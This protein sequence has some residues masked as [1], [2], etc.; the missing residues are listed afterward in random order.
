MLGYIEE[1][2]NERE[3]EVESD[4]PVNFM[5]ATTWEDLNDLLEYGYAVEYDRIIPPKK[6]PVARGDTNQQ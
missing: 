5:H 4:A 6:K 2:D 3:V 1:K